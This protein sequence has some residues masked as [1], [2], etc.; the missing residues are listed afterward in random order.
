MPVLSEPYGTLK[1]LS[2]HVPEKESAY[3]LFSSAV[4]IQVDLVGGVAKHQVVG[5]VAAH[6]YGSRWEA[7]TQVADAVIGVGALEGGQRIVL[8]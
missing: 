6:I 4:A 5:S 8:G 7:V 2:V 1:L 3:L